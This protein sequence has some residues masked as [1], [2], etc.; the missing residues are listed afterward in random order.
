MNR[1]FRHLL[2]IAVVV[3]TLGVVSMSASAQETSN[4]LRTIT[5]TG[6]G[7]ASGTPDIA[8]IQLGVDVVDLS[9]SIAFNTANTQIEAIKIVLLELGVLESDIQT[10]GFNLWWNDQ[11][12]SI[13]GSATGQREY[14]AQHT[15]NVTVRDISQAG[16]VIDTA[17]NAGANNIFGL[18]F[19]LS[20]STELS[21]RARVDALQDAQKRAEL[22]AQSIGVS[23]GEVTDVTEGGNYQAIPY[24]AR[25]NGL[26]GG[27][28]GAPISGGSLAVESYMSVTYTIND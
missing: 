17:V 15:L 25:V 2:V 1:I 4:P 24:S 3:S 7:Q 22:I 27:D 12:D 6:F 21:N 18:T 23:L 16:V 10:S 5:V 9:P 26:G 13:T 8:T 14:H 28:G 19:G 11:Y 20:D